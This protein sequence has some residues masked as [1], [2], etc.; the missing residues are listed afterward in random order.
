[1]QPR[2]RANQPMYVA[3]SF[4]SHRGHGSVATLATGPEREKR[5]WLTRRA[6]A[7]DRGGL[8]YGD[9]LRDRTNRL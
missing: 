6:R 9:W 4:P 3:R 8:D 2:T 5:V 1:M 7:R